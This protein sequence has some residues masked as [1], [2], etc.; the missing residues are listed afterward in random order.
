MTAALQE[1]TSQVIARIKAVA[2]AEPY[3]VPLPTSRTG[4]GNP[5]RFA[6]FTRDSAA[7]RPDNLAIIVA[8]EPPP[9]SRLDW[10]RLQSDL[11][12]AAIILPRSPNITYFH[13]ATS[14]SSSVLH[15]T[16][17]ELVKHLIERRNTLFTPQHLLSQTWGQLSFASRETQI[18]ARSFA[19]ALRRQDAIV[20][21][22][23]NTVKEAYVSEVGARRGMSSPD[24]P[25]LLSAAK[26]D[27]I[28]V[29]LAYVA[30]RILEDKGAFGAPTESADPRQVL[31]R[32]LHVVNGFLR[33][34]HDHVLNNLSV[35]T[36]LLIARHL[37]L[38]VSFALMDYRHIAQIY[39]EL[40][41]E[42]PDT[43]AGKSANESLQRHYTPTSLADRILERIP[44]E[45][46][47]PESRMVFDPAAG[48]GSLLLAA[49]R[50]LAAITD[51][52]S[53]LSLRTQYLQRHVA[54]NDID[55]LSRLVTRLKYLLIWGKSDGCPSPSSYL[56]ENLYDLTSDRLQQSIGLRPNVHIANPPFEER[57]G[58]RGS[59]EQEAAKFIQHALALMQVDDFF[60]FI[61]PQ[62]FLHSNT[63][64]YA[65]ARAALLSKCQM[66][67]VWELPAGAVGLK[68]QQGTTVIIGRHGRTS[69]NFYVHR[70]VIARKQA[71][72]LAKNGTFLGSSWIESVDSTAR[73]SFRPAVHLDSG[74]TIVL[75]DLFHV[76]IGVTLKPGVT[77]LREAPSGIECKPYWKA[78]WR[79]GS[80]W[81]NPSNV[82]SDLRLIRYVRS[83]FS[84]ENR[85]HRNQY[86]REFLKKPE[87]KHRDLFEEP[88]ILLNRSVNRDSADPTGACIDTNGFFP[89]NDLYCVS[90]RGRT[91][92]Q[93]QDLQPSRS[94]PEGWSEMR[95]LDRLYWLLG[96]LKSELV[97]TLLLHDRVERHGDVEQLRNLRL[98]ARVDFQIVD[99]VRQMVE[100]AK[101]DEGNSDESCITMLMGKLN[102]AVEASYDFPTR[103]QVGKRAEQRS[104]EILSQEELHST[105]TVTGQVLQIDAADQGHGSVSVE[106]Y[107]LH[108]EESTFHLAFPREMPGWALQGRVFMAEL[109]RDVI[110]ASQLNQRV[111]ALR[112]FRSPPF[113]YLEVDEI[114]T[115]PGG[116]DS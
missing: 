60:G 116:S 31:G 97:C 114:E 27:V 39:E 73:F 83:G 15:L 51:L 49:S 47:R 109:S 44:L 62:T 105:I 64:G 21:E 108:D 13:N 57:R 46:I 16:D 40:F 36:Q 25:N 19:F 2:D 111:W 17:D 37:G 45:Q 113:P 81:A 18:T 6:V 68:A 66:L 48:S 26:E 69:P 1:R 32:A 82:P 99:C 63:H 23:L 11:N 5:A 3:L 53:E 55:M 94:E 93:P 52:P 75:D 29:V 96:I 38:N 84:Y 35:D 86:L 112:S 103:L 98:P 101:N 56:N 33:H 30:S 85:Q 4:T 72:Q 77:P 54:G 102:S 50:R 76:Y 8:T 79:R 42:L 65:E 41:D 22:V 10:M 70:Q 9:G 92:C 71:R 107:G 12:V 24:Q 106:L 7:P 14:A 20:T 34:T 67:E 100:M 90:V 61:L 115:D 28:Q 91:A 78:S 43:V 58:T 74:S 89:N 95:G 80:I 104:S 87:W 88:K 110:Y 59:S